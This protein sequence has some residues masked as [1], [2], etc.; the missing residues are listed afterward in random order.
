MRNADLSKTPGKDHFPYRRLY[1]ALLK[2]AHAAV[3]FET[4][5]GIIIDVNEAACEMYGYTR[6]ELIGKNA[7]D[8]VPP[9]VRNVFPELMEKH[10]KGKGTATYAFGKR[11]DGSVFPVFVSTS[12]FEIDGEKLVAV[13]VQDVS[14]LRRMEGKLESI[15][16]ALRRFFDISADVLYR[17]NPKAGRFEFISS[18]INHLAGRRLTPF[19]G[20]LETLLRELVHPEDAERVITERKRLLSERPAEPVRVDYRIRG[21]KGGVRWVNEHL[22]FQADK[23]YV[24]GLMRDFT[25]L[26]KARFELEE[27]GRLLSLILSTVSDVVFRYSMKEKRYI[28]MSPSIEQQTGYSV[29]EIKGE[30]EEFLRLVMHPD[31]LEAYQE[32]VKN[33]LRKS[34]EAGTLSTR[35]RIIRKDGEIRWVQSRMDF[36]FQGD[37]CFINGV[38]RDITREIHTEQRYRMLFEQARVGIFRT[39]FP[40]GIVI[41]ANRRLAEMFGF[42]SV[43]E[44]LGT[45][46]IARYAS[47]DDRKKL[48]E[49]VRKEGAIENMALLFKR[50]DG[51][52][53]HVMVSGVLREE[54]GRRFLEGVVMDV[55]PLK[56]LADELKRRNEEQQ[57]LLDNTDHQVWY[58]VAPDECGAVNAAR[59]AFLGRDKSELVGKPEGAF[60][61]EEEARRIDEVNRRIFETGERTVYDEWL[62]DHAGNRRLLHITKTPR[63]NEKGEVEFVVCSAVDITERHLI[64]ERIREKQKMESLGRVAAGVAHD[65]NNTLMAIAGNIELAMMKLGPDS[66]SAANLRNAYAAALNASDLTKQLLAYTGKDKQAIVPLDLN[67]IC[68]SVVELLKNTL[69]RSAEVRME[70]SDERPVTE[71]NGEQIRQALTNL[72]LNAA[73]AMGEKKGTIVVRTSLTRMD[74]E[75]LSACAFRG[76]ALPGEY[77]ALEVEDDGIGM[78]EE[79]VARIFEP[80]FSRKFVGRGLGLSA[81]LGI[82]RA[83]RGAIRV[84][85]KPGEGTLMRILLPRSHAAPPPDTSVRVARARRKYAGSVLLVDDEEPVREV[86]AEMLREYGF[87]VITASEG[88]EALEVF[89]KRGGVDFVVLDLTMPGMRGDEVLQE[90]RKMNTSVKVLLASGYTERAIPPKALSDPN[91]RFIQKPFSGEE[92]VS[93]LLEFQNE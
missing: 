52:P 22:H 30:R 42:S 4:N 17:Y 54:G 72:L 28:F 85:S 11:K 79:T 20:D 10:R 92:L 58:L 21:A 35:F 39:T 45:P 77:C 38:V 81:V 5:D 49:R 71:G 12:P 91:T 14:A 87:E 53:I 57:L 19:T 47:P 2:A 60:Q 26:R 36:D 24:D 78:D 75:A 80:F 41:D 1:E 32:K 56:R 82:V 23:P 88:K 13:F 59:A 33:H 46:A 65:F 70:L 40:N 69:A 66:P 83:H 48:I 6:E 67:G 63:L 25:E 51:S 34:T 64:E 73:E 90:I 29:D 18:S 44:L 8:I 89:R 84:E 62:T 55:S 50:A 86:T 9:E 3:F 74:E 76:N 68:R 7:A 16:D 27:R 43:E 31:D 37:D 61:P 93:R 15:E